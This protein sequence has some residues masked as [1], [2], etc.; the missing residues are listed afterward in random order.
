[1]FIFA[2]QDNYQK[3]QKHNIMKKNLFTIGFLALA[4]SLNA[5]VV[6]HVD[7]GGIFYVGENAL[8]YN[9]G[10]VQTKGTGVYDI[11]GNVMVVGTTGDVLKTI[12]PNSTGGNIVLRL[13]TPSAFTTS[14]YGQLYINGLTQGNIT[15]IVDKEY[16][17]TKHG[18]YQ[19]I[20]MPFSNKLISSL[21]T[22]FGKTFGNKRR[23]QNEILVYNNRN[24][25]A[26]NL[27]ISANT[28]KN[29]AYY[30]LGSKNFDSSAPTSGTVYT[31]KGV[32][33]ANGVVETLTDA[34]LNT[35]FGSAGNGKNAYDER[36]N[37]YLQD[38][39]DYLT[40]TSAPWSVATF[41]R[42]IYQF[43]NPYL[44]NL[45]LKYIGV[46]EAGATTDGNKLVQIKGI[47]FDSG[48]VVSNATG[49]T[50]DTNAKFIN[51]TDPGNVP[52]GDVGIVIKPM[53]VFV[54][55]LKG[56]GLDA[57]DR[58]LSFDGL[59]RFKMTARQSAPYDV[60]AAKG[61]GKASTETV[62]QLGI[63]A[64]DANGEELARTYYVVYP[65][66]I[67]GQTSNHTVQ[68]TLGNGSVIGTYE[69][70]AING[71]YDS[72]VVNTYWLYINEA[73]ETD[74]LGKAIP[75][76][77]YSDAIKSLKF[78]I[79]E[80]ADL[81]DDN[82]HVLSSGIGFYYKGQNG[83]ISEIAQNQIVPVS[84]NEYSLYYG[85]AS[86]LGT[87]SISKP[88]RTK[89]VYSQSTDNFMVRFD[90][91]WKK[92]DINVYDMSGK[93]II[94]QKDFTASKDFDILLPKMNTAY[95]VT[96]VSEKGDKISSKI[97]R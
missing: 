83:V 48:N 74:F 40:N 92:A 7:A 21:S 59:R 1:M 36:Y 25:V 31:V 57:P 34:G 85:K 65:S 52:T 58:K 32:P 62:K 42:N 72:N 39:W 91:E 64:L 44:T 97:V 37:S 87:N 76:A 56:N 43:G 30:M 19:Q 95:I 26:D 53:Q 54:I 5:Q 96:A 8:V 29:T 33:Y 63:V 88:S 50:Y 16:R 60:T 41:G 90:P 22:E 75:L 78:E 27:N 12:S 4:V 49:A 6:C 28:P 66:A 82:V 77:L 20:A 3:T 61:T 55:K 93:L 73:N 79:R 94:S 23:S 69:E 47:R 2:T 17:A 51:F 67:S 14:T 9:G 68:T 18:T 46:T 71:G 81:L 15:A 13:N 86:T 24:V 84:G 38:N 10:G 11:H 45:D 89:V 35:P 80:N 70:D